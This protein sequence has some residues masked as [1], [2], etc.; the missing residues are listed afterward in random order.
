MIIIKDFLHKS[1]HLLL[2]ALD[3]LVYLAFYEFLQ[4]L[5][6]SRVGH[7]DEPMHLLACKVLI[8]LLHEVMHNLSIFFPLKETN[9][10]LTKIL[11]RLTI[12]L[13]LKPLYF[14]FNLPQPH[15]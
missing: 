7:G 10:K 14:F 6:V 4:G 11:L 1:P 15:H 13:L 5:K 8:F 2:H 12:Q 9:F 3:V